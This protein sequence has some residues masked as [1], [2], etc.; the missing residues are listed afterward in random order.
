MVIFIYRKDRQN[1]KID[2]IYN[3]GSFIFRYYGF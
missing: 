3:G 1:E 2:S